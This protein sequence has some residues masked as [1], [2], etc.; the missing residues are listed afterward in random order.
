MDK[1]QQCLALGVVISYNMPHLAELFLENVFGVPTGFFEH[2]A[3]GCPHL[4]R[5]HLENYTLLPEAEASDEYE[6]YLSSILHCG[7]DLNPIICL[8]PI[9][10]PSRT[11]YPPPRTDLPDSHLF[12]TSQSTTLNSG[13]TITLLWPSGRPESSPSAVSFP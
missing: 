2:L 4:A 9:C 5:L 7:M 12:M 10:P 1:M 13:V 8:P 6:C 3:L 11:I